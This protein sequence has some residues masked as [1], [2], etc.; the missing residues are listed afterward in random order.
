M[1]GKTYLPQLAKEMN[2]LGK[3]AFEHRTKLNETI[4]ATGMWSDEEKA[5]AKRAVDSLIKSF[6]VYRKYWLRYSKGRGCDRRLE[7]FEHSN[8]HF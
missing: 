7:A 2:Y 4:D 3:Y 1:Y 6:E 5:V 8:R